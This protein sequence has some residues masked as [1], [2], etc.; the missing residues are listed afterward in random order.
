MFSRAIRLLNYSALIS[1]D[2][3]TDRS[4]EIRRQLENRLEIFCSCYY[5]LACIFSIKTIV[6]VMCSNCCFV[7]SIALRPLAE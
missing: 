5:H 4:E 7:L 2:V 1:L 6:F 3:F